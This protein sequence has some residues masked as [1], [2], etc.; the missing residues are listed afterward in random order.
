MAQNVVAGLDTAGDRDGAAV[1]IGNKVVRGP[2]SRHGV[3]GD[4]SALV[5]LEE[6][7]LR[8]IH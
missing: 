3:V 2:C 1:V 8:L 6:L 4:Q 7:E 5:D